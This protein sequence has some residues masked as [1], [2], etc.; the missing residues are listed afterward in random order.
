[1]K[2]YQLNKKN[3][4]LEKQLHIERLEL[5]NI[6]ALD[7]FKPDIE[8]LINYFNEEYKWD[9]M[10]TI[11]DVE[12]RINNGHTIFILYYDK[13]PIG[14]VWFKELDSKTTFGYNLYVTKKIHRPFNS[15]H[16]F[17]NKV[18]GIMLEKYNSIKVEIEDWNKVVFELVKNIGYAPC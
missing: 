7:Y 14:Y 9:N 2:Y 11:K 6:I 12:D 10:F 5:D 8:T 15:A 4:I 13:Q 17:Y 1:V 16:W 3:Y 18:S